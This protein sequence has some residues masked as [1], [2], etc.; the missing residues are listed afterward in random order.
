MLQLKQP[1]IALA[2][3]ALL[4]A[5]GG[6]QDQASP[7]TQS[8]SSSQ[9][10]LPPAPLDDTTRI[11]A[12]IDFTAAL[13]ADGTVYA[14]GSNQYGQLGQPGNGM[15]PTPMLVAGLS[16]VKALAAGGYHAAALRQDGTVWAWGN[17]SY[18][19][20]GNG[21][22]SN[23]QGKPMQVPGMSQVITVSAGYTHNLAVTSD[24]TAWGWGRNGA[25]SQAR[26]VP[27][28]GLSA[29]LAASAGTDFS[30]VINH[31]N[32]VSGWGDNRY[33]QLATR[34]IKTYA[35]APVLIAGLNDIVAVAAGGSHAL[36]LSRDGQVWA[37]GN[38]SFDQ[39]G[40]KPGN[41]VAPHPVKGLPEPDP[42]NP[43]RAIAAGTLNSAVLY[44]DGSV[45]MWGSNL[46]GQFG[47][48]KS[49]SSSK[50]VLVS[51]VAGVAG[52]A[53]GHGYTSVLA[54]DGSAFGMGQ[55]AK[56]QLGNNTTSNARVPVQV[57][58]RSGVGVLNLGASSSVGTSS[59]R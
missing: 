30:L 48:G 24:G 56:G 42:A 31:D 41:S 45:W 54:K 39:L 11:G 36:A 40:T 12:G 35:S 47:D 49:H 32:T 52:V 15:S 43:V 59:A 33:G 18:G 16:G 27:V 8:R 20:L 7:V 2:I 1:A 4:A 23:T 9:Q 21:G 55:N 46:Y 3:G 44:A 10:Q 22:L 19:Q 51:P 58:G 14:W 25:I 57:V 50:P 53:L 26:A 13:H 38:N 6:P 28:Q 34:A 29:V 17:N 5:C 37:W